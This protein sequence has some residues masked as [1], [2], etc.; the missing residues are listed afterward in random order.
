MTNLNFN[1][2]HKMSEIDRIKNE[3]RFIHGAF[4]NSYLLLTGKKKQDEFL[5]EEGLGL[6]V[7]HNIIEINEEEVQ[8]VI[9]YFAE[10]D[11]FNKCIELRDRNKIK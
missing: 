2:F 1:E 6:T 11:D 8:G 4:M 10:L 9:E 7:A 3:N 5:E